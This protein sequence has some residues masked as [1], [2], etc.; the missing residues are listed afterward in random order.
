MGDRL[1]ADASQ[2]TAS[3]ESAVSTLI[4]IFTGET[5]VKILISLAQSTAGGFITDACKAGA[6]LQDA[7]TVAWTNTN[8][9]CKT[10]DAIKPPQ[11]SS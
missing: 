11:P 7:T 9:L 2:V 4:G 1:D 6:S 3:L 8:E 10:A 5:E